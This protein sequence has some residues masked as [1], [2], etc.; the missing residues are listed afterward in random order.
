MLF[1][2]DYNESINLLDEMN[3]KP[4]IVDTENLTSVYTLNSILHE[5]F[6]PFYNTFSNCEYVQEVDS[7]INGKCTYNI[8]IFPYYDVHGIM[9]LRFSGIA[10]QDRIEIVF[11]KEPK[12]SYYYYED[13]SH[14]KGSARHISEVTEAIHNEHKDEINELFSLMAYYYDFRSF[15]SYDT[16]HFKVKSIY[17]EKYS[18]NIYPEKTIYDKFY[19]KI[20]FSEY[21]KPVSDL[22]LV[23]YSYLNNLKRSDGKPSIR[24]LL[25]NNKDSILKRYPVNVDDLDEKIRKIYHEYRKNQDKNEADS[26][27]QKVRTK[28]FNKIV[29]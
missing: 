20:S 12:E 19:C 1:S 18:T 14:A 13:Y 17:L 29:G 4:E 15:L 27:K 3:K 10:N 26:V 25:E 22:G 5:F 21:G 11:K 16:W 7:K 6:L 28:Y 23:Y 24:E 2:K 9:C 8:K